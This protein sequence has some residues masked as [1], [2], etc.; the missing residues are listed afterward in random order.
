ME[1]FFQDPSD[2]PLPPDEVRIREFKARPWPDGR[3]VRVILQ[4]TPFQQ[5]PNGEITINAEDGEEVAS[6][7]I[8]ETIDPSMELTIHLRQP[9]TGGEYTASA[10]LYYTETGETEES[11]ETQGDQALK[12]IIVDQAETRFSI[13]RR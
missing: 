8:I 12:N 1:I 3:R 5:K 6:I 7:S 9:E 10:T 13:E 2:I 4:I 11:G